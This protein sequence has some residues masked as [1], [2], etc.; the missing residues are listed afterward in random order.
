MDTNERFGQIETMLAEMLRR[1]DRQSEQIDDIIKILKEA[2]SFGANAK[3]A[4]VVTRKIPNTVLGRE[5]TDALAGLSNAG[6]RA[7]RVI[8]FL[9]EL[10]EMTYEFNLNELET[11][12]G[13]IASC[14]NC[15]AI[16]HRLVHFLGEARAEAAVVGTSSP[17][18]NDI[19]DCSGAPLLASAAAPI[20]LQ[21]FSPVAR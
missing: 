9:Q 21:S 13:D 10:F 2:R 14:G 7:K 4:F 8:E 20:F 6:T 11:L 19:A 16:R 5:V 3:A 18:V 12:A 17:V 1:M 15:D